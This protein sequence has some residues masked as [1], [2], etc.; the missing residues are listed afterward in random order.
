MRARVRVLEG[1]SAIDPDVEALPVVIDGSWWK[2]DE[3]ERCCW[4]AVAVAMEVECFRERVKDVEFALERAVEG[5]RDERERFEVV[6]TADTRRRSGEGGA[7]RFDV[8][9]S[10]GL[11]AGEGVRLLVLF[12]VLVLVVVLVFGLVKSVDVVSVGVDMMMLVVGDDLIR[13]GGR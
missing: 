4:V 9:E 13:G 7:G 11:G 12:L 10:R 2:E 6:D 3:E 5:G 8:S 1:T